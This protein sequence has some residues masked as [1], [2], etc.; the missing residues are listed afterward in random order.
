M[1][2][3]G[4]SSLLAAALV[5]TAL[6]MLSAAV[7]FPD[8]LDTPRSGAPR[9]VSDSSPPRTRLPP[10]DRLKARSAEAR[11]R[12]VSSTAPRRDTSG[13]KPALLGAVQPVASAEPGDAASPAGITPASPLHD[14]PAAVGSPARVVKDASTEQPAASE[15]PVASDAPAASAAEAQ[16]PEAANQAE[17]EQKGAAQ[18]PQNPAANNLQLP[19]TPPSPQEIKPYAEPVRDPGQLKKLSAIMPYDDYEPD[20]DVRK[21]DR[22]QNLCPRPPGKECPDCLKVQGDSNVKNACPECPDEVRLTAANY[23]VRSFPDM[24]INWEATNV[25]S[26]P[27]YTEDVPLERY[28]HTRNR[29]FQPFF[30]IGK[31]GVQVVG[32]PYQMV[33]TPPR[34]CVY[35]L[36]FYRPG[37][38]VP[39]MYYQIP[40]NLQA[41]AVEAGVIAGAYFLFVPNINP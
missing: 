27:L 8:S 33:L 2:V 14:S 23:P 16:E 34:S 31:F 17:P 35:P 3:R 15:A 20:A 32:I 10:L 11:W 19:N 39:Y 40:L 26:Y 7:A 13:R 1:Q 30:S 41:A 36:G 18:V 38:C 28:G 25:W 12:E 4:N 5:A 21:L 6:L 29:F 24:G 9:T 37:D 22:C